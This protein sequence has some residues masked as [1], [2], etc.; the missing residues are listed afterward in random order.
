MLYVKARSNVT[1]TIHMVR[2][3]RYFIYVLG[4]LCLQILLGQISV[5]K[6]TWFSLYDYSKWLSEAAMLLNLSFELL[7]VV[8]P[9]ALVLCNQYG[10]HQIRFC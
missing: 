7:F 5:F 9:M 6:D 4:P 3:K 10:E 1:K 2:R 8:K